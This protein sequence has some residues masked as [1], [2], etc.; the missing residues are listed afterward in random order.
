MT[1][2]Q[3]FFCLLVIAATGVVG[4]CLYGILMNVMKFWI[5]NIRPAICDQCN[6]LGGHRKSAFCR[7]CRTK[8]ECEGEITCNKCNGRGRIY[9]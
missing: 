8:L 3:S 5:E 2:D 6:G 9:K 4:A 1:V 7:Q